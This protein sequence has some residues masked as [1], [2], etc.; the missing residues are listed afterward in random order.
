MIINIL[1][2]SISIILDVIVI[3]MLAILLLMIL[4]LFPHGSDSKTSPWFDLESELFFSSAC[5]PE[6]AVSATCLAKFATFT[7]SFNMRWS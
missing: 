2:I 3:I 6:L 7:A 4:C 1:Y 5:T